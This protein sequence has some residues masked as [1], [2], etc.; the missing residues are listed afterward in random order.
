MG[1]SS[2][3]ARKEPE[4]EQDKY[5]ETG[6]IVFQFNVL[7]MAV[8]NLDPTARKQKIAEYVKTVETQFGDTLKLKEL[9]NYLNDTEL[10]FN[11]SP[12]RLSNELN[13]RIILLDFW[14]YCCI[15]CIHLLERLKKLEHK[16]SSNPC[17]QII[18]VHSA[19]FLNE[20]NS[21]KCRTTFRCLTSIYYSENIKEAIKKYKINH[22]CVN[23]Y[24]RALWRIYGAAAWPSLVL[25]GDLSN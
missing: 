3:P 22:I 9:P 23:D 6:G 14:T 25:L 17:F 12:L 20:Q 2:S 13:N 1:N 7:S 21:G 4:E 19:K 10:W 24:K 11:S 18:G 16:Y 8:N 5:Q 15:N